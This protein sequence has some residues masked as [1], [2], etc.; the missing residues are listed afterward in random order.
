MRISFAAF[1]LIMFM[2]S[3]IV[4]YKNRVWA[5]KRFSN[6]GNVGLNVDVS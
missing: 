3:G 4:I 1:G 6:S 5:H 2:I